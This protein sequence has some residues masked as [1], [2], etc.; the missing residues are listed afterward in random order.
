MIQIE[1]LVSLQA[2]DG[3]K[4]VPQNIQGE[5]R[6]V[7]IEDIIWPIIVAYPKNSTYE[8]DTEIDKKLSTLQRIG[9]KPV[10]N[11]YIEGEKED[12]RH[13]ET[14]KPYTRESVVLCRINPE[15]YNELIEKQNPPTFFD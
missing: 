13:P 1:Q 8:R 10:P 9:W 15:L 4:V 2:V 5:K 3:G 6:A 12:F 7:P 14:K 11:A